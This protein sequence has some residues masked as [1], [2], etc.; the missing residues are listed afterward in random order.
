MD[1]EIEGADKKR[2]YEQDLRGSRGQGIGSRMDA[3]LI[4]KAERWEQRRK[5]GADIKKC[6]TGL[7]VRLLLATRGRNVTTVVLEVGIYAIGQFRAKMTDSIKRLPR[8]QD[9]FIFLLHL[10]P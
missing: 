1:G 9:P 8:A 6:F 5:G 7:S 4:W 3:G 2:H 10:A